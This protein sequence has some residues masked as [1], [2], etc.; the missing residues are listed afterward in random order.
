MAPGMSRSQYY[1]MK[2]YR[3]AGDPSSTYRVH[4]EGRDTLI[5]ALIYS[6]EVS[7]KQ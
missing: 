7:D 6:D 3:L 4:F 2:T 5:P 1:V